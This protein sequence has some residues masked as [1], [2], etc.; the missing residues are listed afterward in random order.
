[1]WQMAC[2]F[3]QVLLISMLFRVGFH[4]VAPNWDCAFGDICLYRLAEYKKIDL[5]PNVGTERNP[6]SSRN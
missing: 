1:M 4:F 3:I 5:E 2:S 6:E